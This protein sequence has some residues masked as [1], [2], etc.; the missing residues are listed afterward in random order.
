M[1]KDRWG[2]FPLQGYLLECAKDPGTSE[3]RLLGAERCARHCTTVMSGKGD[4]PGV[5]DL[6]PPLGF[7]PGASTW[8]T[9]PPRME[10]G[11]LG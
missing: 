8:G 4:L 2:R 11:L 7:S 3:K 9:P 5:G 6:A 10:W 1:E